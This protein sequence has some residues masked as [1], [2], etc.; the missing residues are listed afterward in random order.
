MP[1]EMTE[2]KTYEE[3][4]KQ[5]KRQAK[6]SEE[7]ENSKDGILYDLGYF[8]HCVSED[9]IRLIV[10]VLH[11]LPKN[12]RK[13][14]LDGHVTFIILEKFLHGE[15][16]DYYCG[17]HEKPKKTTW[18]FLNFINKMSESHRMTTIA[19]EI[20][21]FILKHD[22]GGEKAENAVDDL[23]EKWGFGR[24]YKGVKK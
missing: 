20:A 3:F 15:K 21:H 5:C 24:A 8:P 10:E 12:V 16:I 23:C 18:L 11:K 19:H 1:E 13:K 2:P 6:E 4:K 14:V 17:P 22:S 7:W 9:S